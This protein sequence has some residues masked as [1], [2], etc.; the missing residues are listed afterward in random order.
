MPQMRSECDTMDIIPRYCIVCEEPLPAG[1]RKDTKTCG[2]KCRKR[3]QRNPYRY[4]KLDKKTR[5]RSNEQIHREKT[6]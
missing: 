4:L 6:T 3:L 2:P 1:C 5:K